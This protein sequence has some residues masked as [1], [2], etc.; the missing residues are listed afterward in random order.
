MKTNK[1]IQTGQQLKKGF[2]N[3]K[4]KVLTTLNK[5][6]NI[7]LMSYILLFLVFLGIVGY[8]YI[9]D[10]IKYVFY[11]EK[12]KDYKNTQVL[13]KIKSDEPT[14]LSETEIIKPLDASCLPNCGL[15]LK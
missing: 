11:T 9:F 12:P 4:A 2:G 3:A 6:K 14:I 10:Y 15:T 1:I 8:Q 5:P 7:K 13:G